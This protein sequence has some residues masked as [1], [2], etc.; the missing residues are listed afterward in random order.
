[1]STSHLNIIHEAHIHFKAIFAAKFPSATLEV[2]PPDN[3]HHYFRVGIH[4][5]EQKIYYAI[6]EKFIIQGNF[7]ILRETFLEAY[8]LLE[9]PD[10]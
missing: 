4:L 7:A 8:L 5:G 3:K 10:A 9:K 1:M 6:S 2:L